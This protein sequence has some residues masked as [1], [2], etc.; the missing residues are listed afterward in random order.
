M[1][2]HVTRV[3]SA[4]ENRISFIVSFHP[5]NAYHP[6]RCIFDTMKVLDDMTKPGLAEYEYFRGK[7]WHMATILKDCAT[8]IRVEIFVNETIEYFC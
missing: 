7:S 4:R 2:H 3:E 5:A 6:E 1:A 8:T